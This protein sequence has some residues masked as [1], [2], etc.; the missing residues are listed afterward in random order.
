M[1]R[2]YFCLIVFLVLMTSQLQG[3]TRLGGKGLIYVHSAKVISKGYLE[4]YAG[5]RYFGKIASS[6]S[7]PYTLWNVQGFSSFN[8]GISSHIEF[9]LSPI[10]YQD[11]NNSKGNILHGKAN[12]PD[13]LFISMKVGSLGP[14]ESPFLFGGIL[15][16]RI[17]TAK[18]HNI[19]YEPYSA[20]TIEAEVT[21]LVS[22][23]SNIVFPEEGWSLHCN[24]GYLNHNDVGKNLTGNANDPTPKSMSSEI[25]F[26]MGLL[27]PAGSFDFSVE[28]NAR[29]FLTQPPA[30]AYSREYVSYLTTGVYYKPYPWVTLEMGIDLRLLSGEDVS[31]Y[32][33]THLP[34]PPVD[35]PNY[36]TW[37]GLL[38]AKLAILPTRLYSSPDKVLLE[39]SAEDRKEILERI[40]KGQKDTQDADSELLKIRAERKKVEEELKRLR[41]LLEEEKKKKKKE[42]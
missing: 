24:V 4:F 14:L 9:A 6:G 5:T 26:G 36:P 29:A 15:S 12:L 38:G 7:K 2:M 39:K 31:D 35:F 20:G 22:Y 13:D 1:R 19:I 41:K 18:T 16:A 23:Y 34:K 25:L 27:Y 32:Q 3:T 17:P 37:R 30:T 42:E 11:T 40:I 28:F 21:G 33:N 8:V 10:Y